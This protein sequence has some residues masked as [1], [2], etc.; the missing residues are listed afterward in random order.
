MDGSRFDD[1]AR[2]FAGAS[3]RRRF[4]GGLAA[5]AV[6]LIGR[7]TA[8]GAS[9]REVGTVCTSNGNCCS[10]LCGA[11]DK[12]ARRRCECSAGF[13]TCNGDCVD[14]ATAYASDPANCGACGHACPRTRCQVATCSS[15]VCGLAPDATSVGKSCDGGNLCT[16]GNTCQSDGSCSGTPITCTAV[17]QCHTAGVC[18]PATGT[19][20]NP[21]KTN[22]A[23]CNDGNACT[24]TDTCQ[25]G[26]CTG[27]NPVV[28][29]AP[30]Q[31][32][33]TG[34]CDPA[35]G[36]CSNPLKPNGSACNDGNA[37]TQTDTCQAGVCTG[38]NP[39]V[40]AAPDQCHTAGVCNS[41]TGICSNPA[42]SDGVSCNADNNA[43]T[44]DTCQ[45]GICTA[46]AP[47]DC[48][49]DPAYNDQ[50][51]I[52]VCNTTT[53]QCEKQAKPNGSACDD[54]NPCTQTDTCQAGVCTGGNP[55]VC[56]AS[57]QCH[58][59]G[60][61]NP[62]TGVCTNPVKSDGTACSDNNA[63][64]N[65]DTCQAGA[66]V[67]GTSVVCA[68]AGPCQQAGICNHA[69][70]QCEYANKIGRQH[71]L[72]QQPLHQLHLQRRSVHRRHHGRLQRL[73]RL[74]D[75]YLRSGHRL[76]LHRHQLR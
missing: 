75:R 44:V 24:Q 19:C 57:D 69:T 39:V 51:H 13:A 14:P 45:A 50:C 23:S 26:V 59:T 33:A 25:N 67:P 42:K 53:G 37:C 49:T 43:C 29:T 56:T 38:G 10:Q 64:T 1:L 27:G 30:D 60:V 21:A 41:A 66:C 58:L 36:I 17:D 32:H 72:R 62:A 22:G 20:S 12:T 3:S 61:C 47:K 73:Q 63:C 46:G 55:V 65:T 68:P 11:P 34:T 76:R 52:G 40:C 70:G 18:N 4:L 5:G 8:E 2:A 74:H 31:C 48:S 6:G 16:T 35:T 54:G 7:R 71:L 28:C 9:C 15:G